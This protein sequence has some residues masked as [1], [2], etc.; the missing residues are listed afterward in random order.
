MRI[1]VLTAALLVGCTEAE[2]QPIDGP[3]PDFSL[4]D[5]NPASASFDTEV[6]PRDA[7]GGVSA[8]YFGHST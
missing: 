8:W 4:A 7:L 6:S 2:D 5:L 1:T 3:L